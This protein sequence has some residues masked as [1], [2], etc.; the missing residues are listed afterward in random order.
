MD[1]KELNVAA[2]GRWRDILGQHGVL[3]PPTNRHG[4]CPHCGGKDRFRFDDKEGRGTWFCNQC[5]SGDGPDLLAR[6]LGVGLGKAKQL[7]L[8]CVG[9]L[10]EA[11]AQPAA[12]Y[13]P[14]RTEAERLAEFHQH[15]AL[16]RR[17]VRRGE[18]D[19]LKGKGY[20]SVP[21]FLAGKTVKL[22]I[23]G[24][25]SQ[26]VAEGDTLLKLYNFKNEVVGLQYI[27][28]DGSRKRYVSGSIKKGSFMALPAIETPTRYVLAEGYATAWAM[29]LLVPDASVLVTFD[30]GNHVH[31]ARNIRVNNPEARICIAADNDENG[32]GIGSALRA[33]EELGNIHISMPT[34]EGDFDDVYRTQGNAAALAEFVANMSS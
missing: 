20:G 7:A 14:N 19:Y 27:N 12:Q 10:P 26:L 21:A 9:H 22:N 15:F 17:N 25:K 23:H 1:F 24:G 2:Q 34:R 8:E 16:I 3:V 32:T 11:S 33:R 13:V 6:C 18:C 28:A 30:A 4:S 31:V 5:G 29:R